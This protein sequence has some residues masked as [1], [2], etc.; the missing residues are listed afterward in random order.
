MHG[1]DA[2]QVVRTAN[3]HRYE[4]V[5]PVNLRRHRRKYQLVVALQRQIAELTLEYHREL[6]QVDRVSTLAQHLALRATLPAAKQKV[7]RILEILRLAVARE[8]LTRWQR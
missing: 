3:N 5:A 6:R 1:H 8:R 7:A 4:T 2:D